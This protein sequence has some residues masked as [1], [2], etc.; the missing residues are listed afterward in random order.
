MDR[1]DRAEDGYE[2]RAGSAGERTAERA[3]G[4]AGR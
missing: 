1:G 3:R 2:G 4:M